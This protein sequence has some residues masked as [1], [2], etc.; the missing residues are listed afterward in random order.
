MAKKKIEQ[1][2]AYMALEEKLAKARGA[3]RKA[4][5]SAKEAYT[6]NSV[7]GSMVKTVIALPYG[8][9]RNKT[10]LIDKLPGATIANGA[11]PDFI[12]GSVN[13][14]L[15]LYGKKN[16][17]GES[18]VKVFSDVSDVAMISSGLKMGASISM[19]D[20]AADALNLALATAGVPAGLPTGAAPQQQLMPEA[21][22]PEA[23]IQILERYTWGGS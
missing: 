9:L 11:I 12:I 4:K 10:R 2:P 19:F 8:W 6:E 20:G 1:H 21:S 16:G 18:T 15:A 7:V 22:K 17:W 5:E 13:L 14:G 3:V 23:P